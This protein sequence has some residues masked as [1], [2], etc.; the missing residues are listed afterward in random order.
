MHQGTSS[1]P[2]QIMNIVAL[3]GDGEPGV[4]ARRRRI[5][6]L[7]DALRRSGEGGRVLVTASIATL[8]PDQQAAILAA[9]AGFAAFDDDND[10]YGEHDCGLLDVA[11]RLILF[12]IDC[13]DLD[14]AMHSPDSADPDVTRRVLTVMLAAVA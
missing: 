13:Y 12:R 1:M 6:Q 14:L 11:G 7:N 4:A 9:V 10:P 5:R 2:E 8:P 3:P